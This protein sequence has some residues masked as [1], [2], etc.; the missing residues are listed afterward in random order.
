MS[1]D[2]HEIVCAI[3]FGSRAVILVAQYIAIGYILRGLHDI[4]LPDASLLCEGEEIDDGHPFVPCG[5]EM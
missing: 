5:P 2:V 3:T 1:L 4:E